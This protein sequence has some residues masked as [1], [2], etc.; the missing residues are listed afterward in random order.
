MVRALAHGGN[1]TIKEIY[2]VNRMGGASIA[3]IA[4]MAH[5]PTGNGVVR[6]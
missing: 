1:K 3:V 4:R 2:E 5:G 6:F